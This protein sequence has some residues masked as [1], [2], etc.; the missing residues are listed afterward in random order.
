MAREKIRELV[1]EFYSLE[2]EVLFAGANLDAGRSFV[3]PAYAAVAGQEPDEPLWVSQPPDDT[4]HLYFVGVGK[5]PDLR[6]AREQSYQDALA[7]ATDHWVTTLAPAARESEVGFDVAAISRYLASAGEVA[8]T[9]F[10][11]EGGGSVFT[12]YTLMRVNKRFLEVDLKILAITSKTAIPKEIASAVIQSQRSAEEYVSRRTQ[13]RAGAVSLARDSLGL[14]DAAL[15][16]YRE[17]RRQRLAGDFEGGVRLLTEVTEQYPN[18]YLAWLDLGLAYDGLGD[19]P[20]ASL[21]LERAVR[22][23]SI[24][25]IGDASVYNSYG[26]ILYKQHRYEEAEV[27]LKKALQLDPTHPTAGNTLRVVLRRRGQ[28]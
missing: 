3:R 21:S 14:D 22:L 8:E 25:A 6:Q 18:F 10:R 24:Y 9:F 4:R 11:A 28:P 17:G 7:A 5:D 23:D 12:Y 27:Q 13:I 16:R 2:E 15:R 19:S 1:K 20:Q 26:F